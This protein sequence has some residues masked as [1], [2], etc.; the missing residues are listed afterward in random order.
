MVWWT[1]ALCAVS[2]ALGSV[3]VAS[4]GGEDS[5]QTLVSWMCGSFTSA[6]QSQENPEYL[7]VRLHTARI[8]PERDDGYWLYVEQAMA[9]SQDEPHRQR[10]YHL[11]QVEAD[12]FQ[13]E[14]FEIRDPL[15]FAGAWRDP[16]ALSGLAPDSLEARTGCAVTLRK[17]ADAFVGG[18]SG[19]GCESTLR[20]A[21]F[22]TSDVVVTESTFTTWDRGFAATGVQVWGPEN[23]GYVFKRNGIHTSAFASNP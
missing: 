2:I 12:V 16:D 20:G 5:L 4:D 19:R 9:W 6:A 8:W 13:S 15:R 11:T 1:R 14:A 22:V 23:G 3:A 18:T 7:D 17:Q 21:A 10:V